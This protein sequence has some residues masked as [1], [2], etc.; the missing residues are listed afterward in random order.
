M[1]R[2]ES[3]STT[4]AF[5]LPLCLLLWL[6]EMGV[7]RNEHAEPPL[8]TV[9]R[10]VGLQAHTCLLKA[11]S[12]AQAPKECLAE[13]LLPLTIKLFHRYLTR[14]Q[15]LWSSGRPSLLNWASPG[16]SPPPGQETEGR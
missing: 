14:N 9:T 5:D 6:E 11:G 10:L 8:F 1:D 7:L 3:K 16:T 2:Q 13:S 12:R 15:S 4:P